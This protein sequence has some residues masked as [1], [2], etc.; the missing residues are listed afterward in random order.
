MPEFRAYPRLEVFERLQISDGLTITAERWREAHGYHRQRQNFQYQALYEPGIVYGLGVAP[1]LDQP[2]GRLL[3]IQPGVAID[4][5]GNPIVVSLP[6]EFRLTSEAS[7]GQSLLV[8]LAVNYVDPDTLRYNTTIR[9][10]KETFRIVEKL[11]LGPEDVEICR[12]LLQP[13]ATQIQIPRDVFRPVANELDFRGR[14]HP[15]PYPQLWVQVGQITADRPSQPGSPRGFTDLLRS[16]PG[17]YPELRG[18]PTIQTYTAQTLGRESA[19]DCH[20]LQIPLNLLL[21]VPAPAILRLQTYLAQGGLL[22]VTADFADVNLLDLLDIGYELRSGLQDAERDRDLYDQTGAQLIAEITANQSAINQ[23][24]SEIQQQL[25][26]M[27]DRLRVPL[28][29]N[30]DLEPDHPLRCHPFLFSQ[31]PERLGHPIYVKNW[32]GLVLLVG[33]LTVCWGRDATPPLSREVLRSAQEWGINLLH[34]AAQRRQWL[35]AMRSQ[36]TA[37]SITPDSLQQRIQTS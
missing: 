10:V 12:V 4:I 6:E 19:L 23:R 28:V 21:S 9:S 11:H 29:G 2:D 7:E 5:E 31:N 20:L 25:G 3:Q 16:L 24:L 26:A 34:F 14:Y 8:Y 27:A 1:L 36:P 15:R 30:G 33:D 18:V 35:Q 17:L 13:G 32:G 37:S 22:L